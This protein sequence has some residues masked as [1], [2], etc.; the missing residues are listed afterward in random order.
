VSVSTASAHCWRSRFLCH[1]CF[2]TPPTC[3]AFPPPTLPLSL[4]FCVYVSHPS[5]APSHPPF[6]F[7]LPSTPFSVQIQFLAVLDMWWKSHWFAR[8]AAPPISSSAELFSPSLCARCLLLSSSLLFLSLF[9]LLPS[10]CSSHTQ[11]GDLSSARGKK[12]K[13]LLLFLQ[14]GPPHSPPFH[15]QSFFFFQ[16]LLAGF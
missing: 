4:P 1:S 8:S 15:R 6:L 11:G 12:E 16:S 7:R 2:S 3:S 14:S 9:R 13:S 10:F 5:Y